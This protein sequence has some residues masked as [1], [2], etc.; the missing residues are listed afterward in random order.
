MNKR[1]QKSRIEEPIDTSAT[2]TI[3]AFTFQ[4]ER[5]LYRLFSS[6]YTDIQV[7]LETLDDVA[8]L[9][10]RDD[11]TVEARLEQDANTLQS[12]GQPFQDSSRKLWHTLRVWLSHLERL[13]ESYPEVVFCAVTNVAVPS[14]ALI[15]KLASATS[16]KDVKDVV[17]LVRRHAERI[18]KKMKSPAKADAAVVAQYGDVD[19]AYLVRR[20]E[21]L[22][23]GGTGSGVGPREATIQ[24][25]QLHSAIADQGEDIYRCI[26]GAAVDQ[27]QEAWQ[28]SETAWLSP[29]PFRDRLRE[30]VDRRSL[31][32]YLDRPMMST[33][34][35]NYVAA[36]GRD[37]FFLG[38]LSRLGLPPR[39]IDDHLNNYWAFYVER[40]RLEEDGV[41][42]KDWDAREDE[43]HQRWNICRN[44]AELELMTRPNATPEELGI[45]T[46]RI[47]L[48]ASYKA[49]LG[50]YA[51][52][53]LYFTHG[54]YH[55]LANKPADPYFVYWHPTFCVK[56]GMDDEGAS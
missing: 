54:H 31:D 9:M 5:A 4:F 14:R 44:N 38:Q 16:P 24:L 42:Q 35:K 48:D 51:T 45:L 39:V 23:E 36:G 52:N 22:H 2:P 20:L 46:L 50:R 41:S 30:E 3:V 7:G 49:P 8:A 26:L 21:L 13:R 28:N 18:D 40:V 11:G 43:L 17:A 27:C 10:T 33:A 19:L 55:Q 25:F 47:T 12:S 37:H 6:H 53:N 15:H 34:F 56:V 32:K 1:D 29:Q